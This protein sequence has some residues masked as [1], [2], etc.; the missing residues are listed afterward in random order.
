MI[1]SSLFPIA[2]GLEHTV[3]MEAPT[4]FVPQV[5]SC[6][7]GLTMIL[8]SFPPLYQPGVFFFIHLNM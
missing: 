1:I 5:A 3:P 6:S 8:I 4:P 2:S 7:S